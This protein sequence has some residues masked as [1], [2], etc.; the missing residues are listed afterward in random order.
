MS[1]LSKLVRIVSKGLVDIVVVSFTPANRRK[2]R[3][4]KERRG[5]EG[6]KRK[7]RRSFFAGDQRNFLLANEYRL[8]ERSETEWIPEGKI[9]YRTTTIRNN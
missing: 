2:K 5:E 4:K 6:E 9:E 1:R 3:E 7:N 8:S